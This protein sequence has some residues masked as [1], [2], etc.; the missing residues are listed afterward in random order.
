MIAARIA[1]VHGPGNVGS[2]DPL[3]P[4]VVMIRQSM[5]CERVGPVRGLKPHHVPQ[6]GTWHADAEHLWRV[7]GGRNL[8]TP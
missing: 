3:R 4:L 2:A 7:L 5:I 6:R 8:E 1:S